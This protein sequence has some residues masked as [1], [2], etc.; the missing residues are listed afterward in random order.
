MKKI[1]VPMLAATR[2][3]DVASFTGPTSGAVPLK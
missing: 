1:I 2:R 3:N